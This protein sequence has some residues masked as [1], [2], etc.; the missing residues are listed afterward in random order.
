MPPAARTS[1]SGYRATRSSS[2][3]SSGS[4]G[5][6]SGAPRRSFTIP[7]SSALDRPRPNALQTFAPLAIPFVLLSPFGPEAAYGL[8]VLLHVSGQR[9]PGGGPG[10]GTSQGAQQRP[11]WPAWGSRWLLVASS[12]SLAADRPAFV[13]GLAPA[14]L[15]GLDRA[16]VAGASG[17]VWPAGWRC[18]RWRPPSRST[19]ISWPACSSRTRRSAGESS[20]PSRPRSWGALLVFSLVAAAGVVWLW[21][22]P[23]DLGRGRGRSRGAWAR[24]APGSTPPAWSRCPD[25]ESTAGSASRCWPS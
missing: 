10:P 15:W 19:R 2:T 21:G 9:S 1:W 4:S 22:L 12:R 5:M 13:L 11:P 25:P 23:P 18:S 7:T 3:T 24:G 20:V 17:A 6:D 16:L 8:L 14:A